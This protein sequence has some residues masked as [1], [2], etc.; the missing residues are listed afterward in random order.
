MSTRLSCRTLNRLVL[1]SV[2]ALAATLGACSSNETGPDVHTPTTVKLFVNG[3]DETADLI[4]PAGATTLVVVKFYD[5][6][7][8]E[9]TTIETEHFSTLTFTPAALA[10]PADVAGHHFQHNVTA[11]AADG[12]GTV[13]VGFG[14]DALADEDSFGPYP[15]T[16]AVP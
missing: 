5:Q 8:D 6:H 4:L 12:T 15:V 10:T 11:Q 2:F 16:V 14:H 3:V 1:S 7:G 13:M 9:M